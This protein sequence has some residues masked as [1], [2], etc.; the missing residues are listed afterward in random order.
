[1]AKSGRFTLRAV[2]LAAL[3][4]LAT[5]AASVVGPGDFSWADAWGVAWRRGEADPAGGLAHVILWELRFPRLLLV[6]LVGAALSVAGV[7]TQGLFRNPLA[8]PGILGVSTGAATTVIAG[9]ALGLDESALWVSP[10]LA[11]L[12]AGGTLAALY[13]L[14]GPRAS[15]TLLLL[16]GVALSCVAGALGTCILSLS[17]D[18]WDFSRKALAWML[19]SFDGRGWAHVGWGVTPIALGLVLAVT[20]HRSLDALYLGEDTAATLGVRPGRLRIGV[21]VVVALLVGTSTALVGAIGFL[22]LV[23]PHIARRLAPPGHARLI[24]VSALLGALLLLGVDTVTRALTPRH[25]A[26][27]ALTSLIG[28]T[29]FAWLLHRRRAESP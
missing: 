21:A 9:F 22:G 26:P 23:V 24:V 29:F 6:L 20:M 17:L 18:S 10:A 25:V 19:G 11:G 28:G 8:E 14:A 13:V 12:G 2:V 27:G 16:T 7:V 5:F 3:V 1:M 15:S 4:G